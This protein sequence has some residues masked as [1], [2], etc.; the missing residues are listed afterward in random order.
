MAQVWRVFTAEGNDVVSTLWTDREGPVVDSRRVR[1]TLGSHAKAVAAARG[2]Q[3]EY[4]DAR[5]LADAAFS[6]RS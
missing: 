1:A 2:Y 3:E 6:D 4:D 5:R